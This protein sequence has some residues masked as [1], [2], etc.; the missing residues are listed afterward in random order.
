MPR[1]RDVRNAGV[2]AGQSV[3]L[4][5]L[6]SS[7]TGKHVKAFDIG[8]YLLL[9]GNQSLYFGMHVLCPCETTV[10]VLWH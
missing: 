2:Q 1:L 6:S 5:V 7:R 3:E 9:E 10:R 8:T 4:V